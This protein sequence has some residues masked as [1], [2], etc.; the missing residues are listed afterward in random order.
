MNTDRR[1]SQAVAPERPGGAAGSLVAD[2]T[3]KLRE[4]IAQ[5]GV[6]PG[7]KI[8]SESSICKTFGVSRST[9]REALKVLEQ[10]GIVRAVRG[11]GRYLTGDRVVTV[12]SPVTEYQSVTEMLE[13]RGFEIADVVLRVQESQAQSEVAMQLG[14]AQGDPVI[15]LTRLR[16]ANGEP[17]VLCVATVVRDAF[18]GPLK[19]RDWRGSVVSMLDANGFAIRSAAATIKAVELPPE[20]AENY[21]LGDRGPWLLTEEVCYLGDMTPVMVALDYHRGDLFSLEVARKR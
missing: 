3:G 19:F 16:L 21:S 8:P 7:E 17:A 6:R 5:L 1:T 18:V 2:L 20:Y 4:L 10:E 13:S 12:K 11:D 9:A 14:I 15:E